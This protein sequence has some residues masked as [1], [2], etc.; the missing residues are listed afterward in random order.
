MDIPVDSVEGGVAAAEQCL[1]KGEPLLAYNSLQEALARWPEHTRL[2]QLQALALARSGDTARANEILSAL[3]KSGVDDPETI[4]L[5]ARTHKDLGLAAPGDAVRKSHLQAGFILYNEAYHRALQ[6]RAQSA[7]WY[8]GINA[9][10]MAAF[11]GDLAT[12]RTIAAEI[13]ALCAGIDASGESAGSGYWR[14]AT[15]GEASLILADVAAARAHYT[16][17]LTLAGRRSGD[18]SSTRRQAK[19]LSQF[20]PALDIDV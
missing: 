15:L 18:V 2:R 17:A 12:A 11:R 14:E 3:A 13:R 4:G 16:E 20:L 19:L 10:A 1:E 8:T 6:D 5:L 9:A 7:A